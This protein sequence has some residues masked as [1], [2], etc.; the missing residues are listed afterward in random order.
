LEE[1]SADSYTDDGI[2]YFYVKYNK[3]SKEYDLYWKPKKWTKDPTY[4]VEGVDAFSFK[5]DLMDDDVVNA[6]IYNCGIDPNGHG[7][8]F[9]HLNT[10]GNTFNGGGGTN[11]YYMTT[12]THI[13]DDLINNEFE[14]NP[15]SFE[16]TDDGTRITNFP[17][18]YPYT[19]T[20]S[21]RNA[22]APYKE[23]GS[24][25]TVSSGDEWVEAIRLEAKGQGYKSAKDRT[26]LYSKARRGFKIL[27]PFNEVTTFVSGEIVNVVAPSF[28]INGI[29]L[30]IDG[31]NIDKGIISL[32]V[33]EDETTVNE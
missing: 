30:R 19:A 13:G 29:N 23:D 20:F 18:A 9:L 32:D 24:T 17:N 6:I 1:L 2:Y 3:S 16:V 14:A 31:V 25:V 4:L 5:F 22:Q 15:S 26:D 28:G 21:G 33:K 8:E 10:G 11:W 12:T 27:L 7:M